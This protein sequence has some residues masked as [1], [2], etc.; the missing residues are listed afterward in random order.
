MP[1]TITEKNGGVLEVRASGKLQHA[2]YPPL[3]A[4]VERQLKQHDK[5]NVLWEMV[6]FHGWEPAAFW[7][8][9]KFDLQHFADVR[10]FAMVGDAKWEKNL[11]DLSRPFTTAEVRYFD[12]SRLDDA[13]RWVAGA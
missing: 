10:R 12:S 5:V 6:D 9:V 7:D 4:T 3:A 13:R 8:D 1:I 11:T 2:D